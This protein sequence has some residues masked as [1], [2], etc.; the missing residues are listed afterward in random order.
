MVALGGNLFVICFF[1]LIKMV[2][3]DLLVLC[4]STHSQYWLKH[5]VNSE[6][7]CKNLT[8]SGY[9]LWIIAGLHV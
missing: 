1:G 7:L 3:S 2:L 4:Y 9:S 5:F 6:I 8:V